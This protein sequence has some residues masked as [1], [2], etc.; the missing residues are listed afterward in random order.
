MGFSFKSLFGMDKIVDIVDKAVVD[1][2]AKNQIM[3]EIEKLELESDIK[4]QELLNQRMGTKLERCVSI[5]F[6]FIGFIFGLYLL[7]NLLSFWIGIYRGIE[8]TYVPLSKE[9]YQVVITYLVGFFGKRSVDSF[10]GK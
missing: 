5:V 2:D 3:G 6:P 8:P 4:L 10:K 7:S 1:K 9:M